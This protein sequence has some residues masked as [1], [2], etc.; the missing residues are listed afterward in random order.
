[1]TM[2][3]T[4][5]SFPEKF[6]VPFLASTISPMYSRSGSGSGGVASSIDEEYSKSKPELSS[7]RMFDA[8]GG[9]SSVVGVFLRGA[10][11]V[12]HICPSLLVGVDMCL[13][14]HQHHLH[15]ESF[16]H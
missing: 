10:T 16:Q 2:M 12:P 7:P 4:S 3:Q 6:E 15:V 11:L 8:M 14:P 5:W 9:C 13:L 1:M